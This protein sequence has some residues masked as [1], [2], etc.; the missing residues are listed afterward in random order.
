MKNLYR[1]G[2]SGYNN[3]LNL[4][5]GH[6]SIDS[7]KKALRL[8]DGSTQGGFEC[9]GVRAFT[10]ND[11]GPGSLFLLAG[12][13]EAGFYGEVASDD[14]IDG[15][16]LASEIG[17]SDGVSVNRST[18][19][20]KF[21]YMG[22]TLFIPKLNIRQNIS[23]RSIYD[24]GALYGT[25][26]TGVFPTSEPRTQDAMVTID[27]YNYRVRLIMGQDADP[28][29]SIG[30]EW[31]SLFYPIHIT[32]ITV[33][34]WGINFN[35]SDIG[36][37]GRILLQERLAVSTNYVRGIDGTKGINSTANLTN[38]NHGSGYLT[39]WRPVLELIP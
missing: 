14:F 21:S 26:D 11:T 35:N 24:R 2:D 25:D 20:L 33:Q 18:P 30:R 13:E 23:W 6:L 36:I 38:I 22:K 3:R 10:P 29:R 1:H 17:L 39:R 19:W 28:A 12:D 7:E 4:P 9:V 32:D 31:S 16:T 8:F 27:G 5:V 15:E 37:E 34:Q